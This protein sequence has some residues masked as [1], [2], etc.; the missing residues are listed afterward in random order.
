MFGP[1]SIISDYVFTTFRQSLFSCCQSC[2][3]KGSKL[4][5]ICRFLTLFED[6]VITISPAYMM[7]WDF[8]RE[9]GKSLIQIMNKSGPRQ[10]IQ[11][12]TNIFSFIN[13][14]VPIIDASQVGL[15]QT[16]TLIKNQTYARIMNE[17][18]AIL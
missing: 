12:H 17:I 7:N 9:N 3:L 11:E 18:A 16:I 15:S 10:V 2:I 5:L 6:R 13:I 1:E 4:M 8:C 14:Q